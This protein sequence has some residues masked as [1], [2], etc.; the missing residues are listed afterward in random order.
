MADW[1]S[2][3]KGFMNTQASVQAPGMPGTGSG[4]VPYAPGAT[5]WQ[6]QTT[7]ASGTSTPA[8]QTLPQGAGNQAQPYQGYDP[9]QGQQQPP[10]GQAQMG[11]DQMNANRI[12]YARALMERLK[13]QIARGQQGN[14]FGGL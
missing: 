3:A 10:E 9:A 8:Q 1:A 5:N 4:N 13:A 11:M 12:A 2:A 14:R 6:H 7:P